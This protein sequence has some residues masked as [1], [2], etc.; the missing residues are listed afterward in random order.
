MKQRSG[1]GASDPN[2]QQ[3]DERLPSSLQSTQTGSGRLEP[4]P[5]LYSE[6][7][8]VPPTPFNAAAE[9]VTQSS[10]TTAASDDRFSTSSL[11]TDRSGPLRTG[12]ATR[13]ET[14]DACTGSSTGLAMD[15]M[16]D[17]LDQELGLTMRSESAAAIV[18][19]TPSF[20]SAAA[21]P[22]AD[23]GAAGKIRFAKVY[24]SL[25]S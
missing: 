6:S 2:Q 18:A 5:L 12:V 11:G 1:G 19:P 10:E 16:L 9:S 20:S 24:R 13:L 15:R 21:I 4:P 7:P 22:V 3:E 25:Q 17:D 23:L 14:V 8:K